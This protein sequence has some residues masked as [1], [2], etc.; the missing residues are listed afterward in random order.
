[1]TYRDAMN[2]KRQE[3]PYVWSNYEHGI[4][5]VSKGIYKKKVTE[6]LPVSNKDDQLLLA[7]I[8]IFLFSP[9]MLLAI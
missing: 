2:P 6:L 5:I 7:G 9:L 3:N 1:M 8:K 4:Y